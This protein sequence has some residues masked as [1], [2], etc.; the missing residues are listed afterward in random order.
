MGHEA[1]TKTETDGSTATGKKFVSTGWRWPKPKEPELK[2]S[3]VS[4]ARDPGDTARPAQVIRKHCNVIIVYP[5][6]IVPWEDTPNMQ[7]LIRGDYTNGICIAQTV[8]VDE[9]LSHEATFISCVFNHMV[10][11]KDIAAVG[12]NEFDRRTRPACP[13]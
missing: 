12:R 1:T 6:R 13:I 9:A 10:M 4:V 7:D 3:T 2:T 11:I 5:R 8:D